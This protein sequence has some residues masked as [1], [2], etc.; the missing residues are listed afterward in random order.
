MDD[1]CQKTTVPV[2]LNLKVIPEFNL[3]VTNLAKKESAN[4]VIWDIY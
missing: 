2:F 1:L 4:S 3:G